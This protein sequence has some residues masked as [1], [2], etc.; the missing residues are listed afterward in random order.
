M[1]TRIG[2]VSHKKSRATICRKIRLSKPKQLNSSSPASSSS[3]S[4]FELSN[5]GEELSINSLNL[6]TASSSSDNTSHNLFISQQ[7]IMAYERRKNNAVAD[8]DEMDFYQVIHNSFLLEL[9]QNTICSQCKKHWNGKMDISKRE[10]MY[11]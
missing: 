2:R 7:K 5:T 3:S 4:P 11:K 9:M 10:G 8:S 6:T 1:P